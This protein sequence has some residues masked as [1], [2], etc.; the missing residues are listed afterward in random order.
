[1]PTPPL[2]LL[3]SLRGALLAPLSA[4]LLLAGGPAT[5]A[6]EPQSLA[7]TSGTSFALAGDFDGDGRSDLFSYSPG[8]ARAYVAL[9][10][11]GGWSTPTC[12]Y[13]EGFYGFDFWDP[14]DRALVL[15]YDNNG[16]DDLFFY[17]PGGGVAFVMRSNRDGTFTPV[18]A[19]W[20]GIGGF[21]FW[22]S[23]DTALRIDY[24]GDGRDDLLM[25]RQGT[26]VVYM[27]RSNGDGSFTNVL[28][29]TS[30]LAGMPLTGANNRIVVGRINKDN[31]DDLLLF[32][33]GT[34]RVVVAMSNWN[35][36][37]NFLTWYN[38]TDGMAGFS[39]KDTRDQAL[40]FDFDADGDEDIFLYRPGAG[41][42]VLVMAFNS[43][44][45]Y[46]AVMYASSW[47]IGGFDL[48]NS[49]DR[50]EPIDFDG[51]GFR[52]LLLYRPGHGVAYVARSRGGADFPNVFASHNGI[53]GFS[54]LDPA[55]TL[56]PFHYNHGGQQDVL[57][58]R[59]SAQAGRVA[60]SNGWGGFSA[61]VCVNACSSACAF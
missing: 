4:C 12:G 59:P 7:L 34:G 30:G 19:S 39:M 43:P 53:G 61:G 49:A 56:L 10:R 55:D 14:K 29:S 37:A 23:R 20:S 26:G 54:L 22:D 28:A 8:S 32:Q 51:D 58:Y 42:A 31:R 5:A 16:V 41:T 48:M 25:Y 50:V 33:P 1:M 21:D 15:D 11:E 3:S 57:G 52:D 13:G 60:M 17:R 38:R 27:A 6:A 40:L 24:N 47:G 2:S 46:P 35:V 36:D 18:N 45:I 44:T 9:A